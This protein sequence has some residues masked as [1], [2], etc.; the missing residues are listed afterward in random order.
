MEYSN[1]HWQTPSKYNNQPPYNLCTRLRLQGKKIQVTWKEHCMA[2]HWAKTPNESCNFGISVLL[3]DLFSTLSKWELELQWLRRDAGW[4]CTKLFQWLGRDIVWLCNKIVIFWI[5][6]HLLKWYIW[7]WLNMD[8]LLSNASTHFVV[9]HNKISQI[10][11][12]EFYVC[13]KG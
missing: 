1:Y 11:V 8:H 13:K 9:I 5:E 4:W 12:N 6:S 3:L 10:K 7:L 2:M